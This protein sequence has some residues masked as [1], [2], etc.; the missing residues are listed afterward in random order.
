MLVFISDT[1]LTDM[2]CGETS[3]KKY[4]ETVNSRAFEKFTYYL[5]EMA[6]RANAK[7]IEIVLLGDIFDVI[8]SNHWLN[9]TIRPWSAEDDKDENGK[10]LQYHTEEIVNG[11]CN[12]DENKKSITHLNTL[13][14]NMKKENIP[15]K[16]TY[17]IGNHDWLINRYAET[18]K[19]IAAFVGMDNPKD[20]E[21]ARF[22]DEYFG[23]E[24]NVFAR[25]GDI[26]DKFNYDNNRDAS[27]LGDAIVIDL[28][29][30][31]PEAVEKAFKEKGISD[32]ALI[33]Q[34]REVD[35]VRPLVDIPLWVL[36]ACRRAKEKKASETVKMAWNDLVDEFL[37]I[38]FI[39]KQDTWYPFDLMDGLQ[40]GLKLSK[41]S[42]IESLASLPLR[43][44]QNKRDDYIDD[45]YNEAR[46][47]SNEAE[48][49]LYGHTHSYT[50]E[51][52]DIVQI[53]ER[54][55][56]KL[57]LNTGTWRKVHTR[58]AFDKKGLEFMNW[59]VMTF[60][61]FYLDGER[62]ER[63]FEVWNGALG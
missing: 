4:G 57:Y 43:G 49:I 55:I 46:L 17:I 54:T 61:A 32:D 14:E 24:Y 36:G 5:T 52:L 21:T 40:M 63:R 60:V 15:V 62:G 39:K 18:R 20:Y 25:H 12:N 37:Q 23:E 8:R 45:A 56:E 28:L 47:K 31:F 44:L 7:I 2:S 48:F 51:P 27:S 41:Y 9:T 35:N 58:T 30:K 38:D 1:H 19:K 50:T 34:I 42:S 22:K 29:N 53:G 13:K 16:F 59:Y 6:K 33:K 11:I 10:G 26:Y 3:D